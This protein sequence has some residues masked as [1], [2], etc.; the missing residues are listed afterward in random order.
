MAPS[1]KGLT[2]AQVVISRFMGLSPTLGS[3]LTAQ[4]LEPASDSVFPSLSAPFPTPPPRPQ[5]SVSLSKI[6]LK[7]IRN[8]AGRK[9]PQESPVPGPGRGYTAPTLGS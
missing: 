1:V 5:R 6:N 8:I 7:K 3:V 4:S 2:S 9:G